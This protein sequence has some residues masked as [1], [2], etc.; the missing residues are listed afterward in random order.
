M[1]EGLVLAVKVQ[2]A[3]KLNG[4][5]YNK[6]QEDRSLWQSILKEQS[7]QMGPNRLFNY[8]WFANR[9]TS[10]LRHIN[11]QTSSKIIITEEPKRNFSTIEALL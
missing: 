11:L 9:K 5:Q 8:Q 4:Q 10:T 2:V 7:Y 1:A 6:K 3:G